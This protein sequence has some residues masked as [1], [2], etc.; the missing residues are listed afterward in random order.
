MKR[1][2]L[3]VMTWLVAMFLGCGGENENNPIGPIKVG[4]PAQTLQQFEQ[5]LD[6][7]RGQL[8]I[9]AISAS[10]T[11]GDN[12][13]WAKAFGYA[14]IE[15]QSRATPTT[16]FHLASLTKS[17]ASTI[18][19]QLV[20]EELINLDDPVQNYSIHLDSPGII[21]VK[22]LLT[23]TSEGTPGTVFRY[24]GGRFGLLD[25]VIEGAT[26]R[27]FCELL[28][29]RIITPLGL[30]RT[31]PNLN[32]EDNC[33]LSLEERVQ[34]TD[35]ANGYD[36]DGRSAVAYPNYF[37]TAAGLISTSLEVAKYSIAI[38]NNMFLSQETQ[39]L[40][41]SQTRSEN[42]TLLPYGLGW[43]V[44]RYRG[45]KLVWHYG[46]WTGNSSLIIKIPERGL[47]FIV[48]ANSDMLSRGFP[49]IGDGDLSVSVVALEFL[50]AFVF[51]NASLP[52]EPVIL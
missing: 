30:R 43:F 1:E 46:W 50:D 17:F 9:P 28:V 15:R 31:V 25:N 47:T 18:I 26:G 33:L 3:V 23:H 24:N 35:L 6:E 10:I 27:T 39:N 4:E 40:V 2:N 13:V 44:Q 38:D 19:M 42:G 41:F 12:I 11:N 36:S 20:E 8:R 34:F 45:V 7:L 48:L 14:D 5:R 32:S 51:G 52:D 29:E 37:G 22:H 16:C 21:R 49:N